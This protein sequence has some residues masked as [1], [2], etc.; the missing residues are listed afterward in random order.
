MKRSV[1]TNITMQLVFIEF[2]EAL[3]HHSVL[4]DTVKLMGEYKI[5]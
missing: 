5:T 4:T 2:T 3:K 1:S